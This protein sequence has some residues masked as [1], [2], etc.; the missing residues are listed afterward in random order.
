MIEKLHRIAKQ[1]NCNHYTKYIGKL[2]TWRND[3]VTYMYECTSCKK[4]IKVK[5]SHLVPS[6]EKHHNY[7][8]VKKLIKESNREVKS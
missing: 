7:R 2:T 5:S 3:N 6:A 4:V 8:Y 1:L